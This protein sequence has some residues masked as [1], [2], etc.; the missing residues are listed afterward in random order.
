MFTDPTARARSTGGVANCFIKQA[1]EEKPLTVHGDGRQTRCFTYVDDIVAGTMAAGEAPAAV[2]HIINL[3]T[4]REISI[5]ELARLIIRLSGSEGG[6]VFLPYE[7][8]YGFSYEDIPR[9]VPDISAARRLL[10][11][12]PAVPLEEGL[13]RTLEWYRRKRGE[14]LKEKGGQS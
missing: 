7:E 9:R 8:V 10:N 6:L 14:E 4:D 13:R 5:L 3:G 2:G 12:Q 1:L 11:F